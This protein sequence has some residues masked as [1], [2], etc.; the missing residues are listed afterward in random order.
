MYCISHHCIVVL[1]PPQSDD[2]WRGLGPETHSALQ[3]RRESADELLLTWLEEA[4]RDPAITAV[5]RSRLQLWTGDE[6]SGADCGMAAEVQVCQF[7]CGG[8][9]GRSIWVWTGCLW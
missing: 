4:C 5:A 1:V 8:G 7:V 3:Q 2:V 6:E 9:G